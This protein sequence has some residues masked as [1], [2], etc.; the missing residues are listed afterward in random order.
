MAELMPMGLETLGVVELVVELLEVVVPE[1]L[2]SGGP[3][4]FGSGSRFS[5][6]E[7]WAPEF[8]VFPPK[9][10]KGLFPNCINRGGGGVVGHDRHEMSNLYSVDKHGTIS[11]YE[12]IQAVSALKNGQA[13]FLAQLVFD[14]RM[15]SRP[16]RV[17]R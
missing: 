6:L 16:A 11:C 7:G 2:V 5:V 15:F 14:S 17:R 3:H 12:R 13:I 8:S 1:A 9:A 10:E 4:G